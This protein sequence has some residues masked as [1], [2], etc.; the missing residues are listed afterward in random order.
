METLKINIKLLM[1]WI[2]YY[3][4]RGDQHCCYIV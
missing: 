4:P 1:N 2:Y 3:A